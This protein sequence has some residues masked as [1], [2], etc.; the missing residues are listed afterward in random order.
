MLV[1]IVVLVSIVNPALL[2]TLVLPLV[3]AVIG[4]VLGGVLVYR[5]SK[6]EHEPTLKN[7][8]ELGS[9]IRFGLG[10]GVILLA[11]K[12]AQVYLGDAG[13]Y[14]AAA[15]AGTTDVDAVTLSTAQLA[16]LSPHAAV[17]AIL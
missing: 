17:F 8:F 4:G 3:G 2:G 13:V 1:R 6:V 10:F 11:T 14:A 7:P 9:A 15:L 12:A 16:G 5:R